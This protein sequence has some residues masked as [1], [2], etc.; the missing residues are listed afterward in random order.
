MKKLIALALIMLL[1]AS[2]A[3]AEGPVTGGWTPSGDPAV[4]EELKDLFEQGTAALTGAGYIPVAYLGSQVVA[5]TNYAF[6][7]RVV[8]AYPG[9]LD[10]PPAYAMVYLYRALDG[11][12][13]VLSIADF[14]IG[15]LCTY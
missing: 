10:T 7:C 3:C 13:S 8:T 9:S 11:S 15:S 4:T 6:L 5:G 1:L 2:A 12:V 14:D